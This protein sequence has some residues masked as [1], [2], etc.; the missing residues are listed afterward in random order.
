VEEGRAL[1]KKSQLKIISALTI[2]E[3]AEKAVHAAK[4]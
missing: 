4:N 1:L 3:A 2:K